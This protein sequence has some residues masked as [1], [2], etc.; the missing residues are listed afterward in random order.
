M[1]RFN[2]K[3]K[4]KQG[5]D[6]SGEVEAST[7]QLAASLLRKR[8]LLVIS[9]KSSSGILGE[10]GLFKKKV[11]AGDVTVF[12]RQLATMINAGL[13]VV[14]AL[15]I[16]RVQASN[17]FQHIVSQVQADVEGG[18]SFSESL[19]RHPSAFPPSYIAL[20]KAGETGGVLDKVLIRLA[21]T[22]E[23]QQEFKG[24]VKGALVYP[25]I[26]IVGMVIVS[27]I[28]MIFVVPKMTELYDQFDS[29]LPLAT[30]ILTGVSDLMVRIWP[31]MLI[32]TIVGIWGFYTYSKTKAGKLRIAKFI[33]SLPIIGDLNRQI[34]L[35]ELS[36]TL[37]MMI[38]AGV[39]ILE[40][41][42]IT[43]GVI[44]NVIIS[45]SIDDVAEKVEKGFPIAY[46]FAK[47]PDSFPYI[48]S[49]MVAVGEETGKMDEVL[50]KLSHVFEVESD[51]K[52]K[53]LTT[54]IE[55]IVMV[56]LGIGVA[57]LVIAIILP[58]Y[59]LTSV[60]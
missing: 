43:S 11:G 41:L 4:N 23:K 47:H 40:A 60:I 48:F 46:S 58:I 24:K 45:S 15:S 54:A 29:E 32:A 6:I 2:Y 28:M 13:P 22:L 38:G 36:R 7:E 33:F 55:P 56:I 52:V 37:A 44:N 51:Q 30:R 25:V 59:N 21:D 17:K 53:A 20:I 12:T 9:I 8:G 31:F 10:I 34:I 16:L 42:R 39:P 49:Q 3:A 18:E 5:Q 1:K 27:V 50:T 35:T 26:I 19:K 57:F 14:E